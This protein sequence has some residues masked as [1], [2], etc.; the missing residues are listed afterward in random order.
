[1]MIR[2]AMPSFDRFALL[3]GT[4]LGVLIVA[5]GI[6]MADDP[7]QSDLDEAMLKRGEV[8]SLE[9]LNE[10]A[11]LIESALSKGLGDNEAFGKKMLASVL[12]EKGERLTG[13]LGSAGPQNVRRVA[14]EALDALRRATELAPSLGPAHLQLARLK[15]VLR[16]PKKEVRESADAAVKAFTEDPQQRAKALV[17]RAVS[18][19]KDEEQLNDLNAAIQDDPESLDAHRARA[20]LRL[21]LD[22][23]DGT[24]K[25]L[26]FLLERDAAGDRIA[27]NVVQKLMDA[28]RQDEALSLLNRSLEI[29]ETAGLY[30]LRAL[31]YRITGKS[32]LA[33]AD[34]DKAIP[35]SKDLEQSAELL[36]QR[37][38]LALQDRDIQQAKRDFNALMR[39][40]PRII[41]EPSVLQLRYFIAVEENRL[42]DAISD[43]KKITENSNNEGKRFWE[44]QLAGLYLQ[45]DR[46]R[47][48]IEVTTQIIQK[49]K[50]DFAALRLRGDAR[51]AISEHKSAIADYEAAI[52]VE[53]KG[54]ET[55]S[56]ERKAGVRNNLAWVLAT[57]PNQE[58]RDGKRAT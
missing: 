10:V 47:K 54:S 25:D 58:I 5:S 46:P 32:E 51:L 18:S 23:L 19:D 15:L 21:A 56:T 43:L 30:R 31:V 26:E 2:S 27:P 4:W 45:D 36:I 6:V 33:R 8:R 53:D 29:K 16:A 35:L 14:K 50:S 13:S 37:A 22:D 1:M 38:Q 9:G 24:L 39:I 17:L 48:S 34:L 44:M 12:L 49:D 41:Q 42:A 3:F 57:S 52:A 20:E 55:I 7:G 11:T 28:E 40:S